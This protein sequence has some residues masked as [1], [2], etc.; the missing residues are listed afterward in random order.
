V[1]TGMKYESSDPLLIDS[2]VESEDW[3]LEQKFDGVRCLASVASGMASLYGRSG[4]PLAVGAS[5]HARLRAA[6]APAVDVILDGE[7][8]ADGTYWV[9]DL[10]QFG[11]VGLTEEVFAVRRK[12]L[13][14]LFKIVKF[15]PGVFL[16]RSETSCDAKRDLWLRVL[17]ANGEGVIAKRLNGRY[18]SGRSSDAVKVKI[19][20]TVDAIVTGYSSD[21]DS[22]ILGLID[23]V[24]V[25]EVGKCSLV[26]KWRPAI[27]DVV[28]VKY[29]YVI[30][31]RIVQPRLLRPRPDKPASECLLTQIEDSFTNRRLVA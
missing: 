19:T 11:P 22:A 21:A 6:L 20:R 13:E 24:S 31:N 26:G 17:L 1:L 30:K 27:G 4:A 18:V 29:L 2:F 10:L 25:T 12:V 23:G 9:F 7:L 8:M 14:D 28:E 3:A 16:V 5:H 15:G